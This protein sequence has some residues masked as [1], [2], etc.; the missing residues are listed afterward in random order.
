CTA[1]R[2]TLMTGCYAKRVGMPGVLFPAAATGLHPSEKTIAE[3]LKRLGYV[4]ICI[5]K[6]HLGDQPEFLPTRRGFDHYFG[7]P[8]S[9]DMGQKEKKEEK[10][11][12]LAARPPL[13]LLRDE[14]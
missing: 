6:W 10:K 3:Y 7:L 11:A 4:T 1:S 12:K 8:Y 13:P 5:G 14:K 9:N 2:T